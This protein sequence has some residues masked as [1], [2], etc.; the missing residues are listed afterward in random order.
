MICG[1]QKQNYQS[2]NE[3]SQNGGIVLFG[4]TFS[5]SIP[6]HELVEYF[7][8]ETPVYNRS[9][10]GLSVFEAKD[11]LDTCILDLQP[12]K[13]FIQLGEEDLE[14]D[15][16]EVIAQYEWLLYQI[17]A[18]LRGSRIYLLSV[19]KKDADTNA[20]NTAL[21]ALAKDSGCRFIDISEIGRHQK[22]AFKVFS[23]LQP[24]FREYPLRF[25]E[26]LTLR[27]I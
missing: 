7:E 15:V 9:I 25:G 5:S 20:L 1:E 10:P 8:V 27:H 16:S 19:Y 14:A 2:L 17:H 13:I 4:S 12:H 23:L 26:A 6:L 18:A 22:P 21:Q 11:Y 3:I 24:F